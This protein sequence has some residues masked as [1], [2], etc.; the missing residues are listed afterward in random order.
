MGGVAGRRRESSWC[1][2]GT[3]SKSA[4]EMVDKGV[5][6]DI[7]GRECGDDG[8]ELLLGSSDAEGGG[9]AAV[10]VAS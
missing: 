6:E 5:V 10:A 2:A 4:G 8:D 7:A 3:M 9:D 1:R